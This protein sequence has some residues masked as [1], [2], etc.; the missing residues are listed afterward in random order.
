M[1]VSDKQTGFNN[2]FN[3]DFDSAFVG[4][5]RL[6]STVAIHRKYIAIISISFLAITSSIALTQLFTGNNGKLETN[7]ELD[8]NSTSLPVI[9]SQDINTLHSSLLNINPISPNSNISKDAASITNAATTLTIVPSKEAH[10]NSTTTNFTALRPIQPATGNNVQN[11]VNVSA[12]NGSS[13]MSV[14]STNNSNGNTFGD[15][16]VYLNV[17]DTNVTYGSEDE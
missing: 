2:R 17:E 9:V 10:Q 1:K 8:S 15:S 14:N 6:I 12:P 16:S 3:D 7:T 11:N 4:P 13:I 5:S